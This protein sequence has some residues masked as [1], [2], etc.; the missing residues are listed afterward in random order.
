MKLVFLVLGVVA[1]I[2]IS[3]EYPDVAI[4]IFSNFINF[5]QWLWQA[6]T[7]MIQGG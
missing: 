1:G 2:Y 3:W 6:I 5:C 4:Q 7:S